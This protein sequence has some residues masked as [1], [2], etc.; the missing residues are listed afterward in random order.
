[1]DIVK[2]QRSESGHEKKG[3][4]ICSLHMKFLQTYGKPD[5]SKI[6]VDCSCANKTCRG[7]DR[8]CTSFLHRAFWG[9]I[10]S[11]I[12]G[13]SFQSWLWCCALWAQSLQTRALLRPVPLL[14][15]SIPAGISRL[16]S[17][18]EVEIPQ[19]SG[20]QPGVYQQS[21]SWEHSGKSWE[22]QFGGAAESLLVACSGGAVNLCSP[23]CCLPG[24]PTGRSSTATRMLRG[25]GTAACL[26]SHRLKLAGSGGKQ[27]RVFPYD[28]CCDCVLLAG[29]G[30]TLLKNTFCWL[31]FVYVRTGPTQASVNQGGFSYW[32]LQ[33][34]ARLVFFL[35]LPHGFYDKYRR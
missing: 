13:F 10:S 11:V 15:H 16:F 26:L 35:W 7:E 28:W 5:S 1:M 4:L 17:V 3:N 2:L 25:A 24:Q 33:D 22:K 29:C 9:E 21:R 6:T 8:E 14:Q 27:V 19:R 32:G 20:L 23:A 31:L 34:K 30:W 12:G 18:A